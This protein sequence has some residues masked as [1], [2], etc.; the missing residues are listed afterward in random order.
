MSAGDVRDAIAVGTSKVLVLNNQT[1]NNANILTDSTGTA[2]AGTAI[3]LDSEDTKQCYYAD[4]TDVLVHS[5]TTGSAFYVVD[6]SGASPVKQKTLAGNLS[7]AVYLMPTSANNGDGSAHGSV[8]RAAGF[9]QIVT[10]SALMA[11]VR[12]NKGTI[13]IRPNIFVAN[14]LGGSTRSGRNDL[15]KWV[16]STARFIGKLECAE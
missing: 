16:Y 10:A 8:V 9:C 11:V 4:G 13:E 15:E 6:C 2:S 7:N 5:G 3:T 1:S 12:I 14:P